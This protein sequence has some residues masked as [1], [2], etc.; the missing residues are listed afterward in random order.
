MPVT[1]SYKPIGHEDLLKKIHANKPGQ[2]AQLLE[3]VQSHVSN[4]LKYRA[5]LL[6]ISSLKR[7]VLPSIDRVPMA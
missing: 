6:I 1:D 4:R 7:R 3:D 2:E 5:S